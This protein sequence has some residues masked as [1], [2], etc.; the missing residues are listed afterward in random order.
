MNILFL[1]ISFLSLTAFADVTLIEEMES[2]RNA[3]PLKDRVRPKMTLRLADLY[4]EAQRE[5]EKKFLLEG[6]GSN[7]EINKYRKK[8][9][10]L[11]KESL[12]GQNGLF[13]RPAGELAVKIH[14]QLARLHHRVQDVTAAIEY[15]NKVIKYALPMEDIKRESHLGLAEIYEEKSQDDKAYTHYTKALGLCKNSET[16]IYIRYKRSWVLYRSAKLEEAIAD[17]EKSLFDTRGKIKERSLQ[18]YILFLSARPTDGLREISL[19]EDLQ[20]KTGRLELARDLMEAYFAAGNNKAALNFLT[21]LNRISPNL[22]D[23][24]RMAEELYGF[25]MWEELDNVFSQMENNKKLVSSLDEETKKDV[26]KIFERL[27]VQLDAER[28]ANPRIAPMLQQAIMSFLDFFPKAKNRNKMME[29]WLMAEN[30]DEKKLDQLSLWISLNL[31]LG[32][33]K[34]A[35]S[36]RTRRLALAEKLKDDAVYLE[37]SLALLNYYKDKDP[38][39]TREYQYLYAYKNYQLERFDLALPLFNTLSQIDNT[40]PRQ[41]GH[42]GTQ[43]GPGYLLPK[44]RLFLPYSKIKHLD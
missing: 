27:I 40:T 21:Y 36:F 41:M 28:E 33:E 31:Q 14:F 7:K 15:Y 39:K 42:S 1:L 18:D 35:V 5:A 17:M 10:S 29:G 44:K 11:Y 9:I 16:C 24:V 37:E 22:Y 13:P 6:K 25:K 20:T 38:R 8:A 23:Q 26:L 4:F 19:M 34:E 12:S 3:L 2:L 43:P 32:Y 30:N